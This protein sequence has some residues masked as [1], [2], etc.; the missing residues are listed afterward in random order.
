MV[1]F[2]A[3]PFSLGKW[4]SALSHQ[5]ILQVFHWGDFQLK[6]T[7]QIQSLIFFSKGYCYNGECP[8]HDSQCKDLWGTGKDFWSQS[9]RRPEFTASI[10]TAGFFARLRFG[11][12][13]SKETNLSF[14]YRVVWS[15]IARSSIPAHLNC[16][17]SVVQMSN[18]CRSLWTF[19]ACLSLD[20]YWLRHG[21][22]GVRGFIHELF[23]WKPERARYDRVRTFDTNKEWI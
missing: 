5:T 4:E 17:H 6:E 3:I 19:C 16:Y 14:S 22:C 2:V 15:T 20:S 21:E 8:T 11:T 10:S 1:L 9:L 18:W 13:V 23:A 7:I 12:A